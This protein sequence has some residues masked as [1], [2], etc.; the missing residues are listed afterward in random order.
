MDIILLFNIILLFMKNIQV[1]VI[2]HEVYKDVLEATIV[3]L[4]LEYLGFRIL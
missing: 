3:S 2:I 4:D 1:Y